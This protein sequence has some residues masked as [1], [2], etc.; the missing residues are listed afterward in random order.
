MKRFILL[1]WACII[2]AA[3]H[4][5]AVTSEV[6]YNSQDPETGLRTLGT[7]SVLIRNGVT[8]RHPLQ[9]GLLAL[10]TSA[11]W[12]YTINLTLLENTSRALPKGGLLMIRTSSG[13]VLE[14]TNLL[15]ETTSQDF[16]GRY[17]EESGTMIYENKGGYEASLEQL[18]K[19]GRSGVLKIRVQ[20]LDGYFDTEYKKEQWSKVISAHVKTLQG[21][22]RQNK[23][24]RSDF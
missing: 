21:A 4:A 13:E 8:D 1:V 23:D 3:A 11:G 12:M 5:Q 2:A 9:V 6:I 10:E 19:L 20:T 24:I 16:V 22:I 7:N 15:A 14:F 18:V 17:V